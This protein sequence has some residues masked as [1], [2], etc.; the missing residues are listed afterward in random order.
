V[1]TST[2]FASCL[3]EYIFGR[4]LGDDGPR[5]DQ[6]GATL[7]HTTSK[8]AAPSNNPTPSSVIT[9]SA[10]PALQIA[11]VG[12]CTLLSQSPLISQTHC[13]TPT[14]DT[15]PPPATEPAEALLS[16]P[17]KSLPTSLANKSP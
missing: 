11:G 16:P 13:T 5:I 4:A 7:K 8:G 9:P 10:R 2:L 3:Q 6:F 14:I 15:A 1:A 12:G 17:I